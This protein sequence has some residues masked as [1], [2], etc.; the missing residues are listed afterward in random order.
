M[1]RCP[2][3]SPLDSL[4]L[5]SFDQVM[6]I[7]QCRLAGPPITQESL[8]TALLKAGVNVAIGVVDEYNARNTRFEVG[9]VRFVGLLFT[10]NSL[11]TNSSPS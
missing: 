6:L 8:V 1:T 7:G 3:F 9:C 11:N 5:F 4:S 10:S 2:F